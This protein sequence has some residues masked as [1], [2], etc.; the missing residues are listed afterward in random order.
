MGEED[1]LFSEAKNAECGFRGVVSG[2]DRIW[3]QQGKLGPG[4]EGL[5]I[6]T[7]CADS[8]RSAEGAVLTPVHNDSFKHVCS[9]SL[10]CRGAN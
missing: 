2:C 3:V 9:L 4:H 5:C 8:A 7:L 10:F 6:V 1:E